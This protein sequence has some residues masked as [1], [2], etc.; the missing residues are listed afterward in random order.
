MG[1]CSYTVGDKDASGDNLYG[2]RICNQPFVD[3]AW[4]AF[5]FD[6]K[7]WGDG[8]GFDDCCNTDKPLARTFNAVWLL[9]YSADDYRNDDYG[10]NILHWASRFVRDQISGYDLRAKCGDGTA[11]ATTFGAGCTEYRETV[12]WDCTQYK[13]KGYRSC[14]S[15]PWWASWLCYAWFWVSNIVCVAW[16]YVASWV[17][18]IGNEIAT[19][20]RIELYNT[21]FFYGLDVPGRAG[22]LVHECRHIA[23][24]AHDA[25]FPSWSNRPPG[26]SGADSSWDYQGAWMYDALYNWWFYADGHR[27]TQAI[28]DRAK[29]DANDVILN[30]FATRPTFTV[31]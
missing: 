7:F 16:G 2:S 3:W 22:T 4:K 25:N 11:N 12:K 14:R 15:W 21:S 10:G 23:G 18:A 31:K 6:G 13:D 27:T 9:T 17:C 5:R 8:W 1:N 30:C 26:K 19:D 24:K 28:R 20:K 29:A